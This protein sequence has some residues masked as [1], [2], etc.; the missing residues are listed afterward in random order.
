MKPSGVKM[1]PE[2][3]P[4]TSRGAARGG[5]AV[6]TPALCPAGVVVVTWMWTT[7][8]PT[9]STTLLTAREYA[10]RSSSSSTAGCGVMR[11]E[12]AYESFGSLISFAI[13][14][15]LM[16]FVLILWC[17]LILG[18]QGKWGMNW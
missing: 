10:S 9:F 18:H 13:L 11:V 2:P 8:A 5:A 17:C 6:G 15:C 4:L 16:V 1:K 14:F 3:E 7:E 12:P